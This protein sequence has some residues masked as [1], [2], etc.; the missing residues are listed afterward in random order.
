MANYE[1]SISSPKTVTGDDVYG[2]PTDSD[3]S[4]GSGW[5]TDSVAAIEIAD[6]NVYIA[7]LDESKLYLFYVNRTSNVFTA[8]SSTDEI[9]DAGHGLISGETVR[10]K[11]TDLP[12]GLAQSTIYYVR[13]VT[14]DRFKV[15]LTAGGVA[16]N[17]T[18][19]GSGVM[20]YVAPSQRS[21]SADPFLGTVPIKAVSGVTGEGE[22]SIAAAVLQAFYTDEDYGTTG[23]LFDADAA[24]QAAI[25][26]WNQTAPAAIR[27]SVG[28]ASANIDTQLATITAKTNIIGTIKALVRW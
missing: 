18:D 27:T 20:V 26:A 19:A 6:T 1:E 10:F 22:E 7:T 17:I 21:K 28:L 14:T 24:K 25:L 5:I 8:D 4:G 16:V 23:L 3:F 9:I 15:S 11:G 13:D 12:A 2:K